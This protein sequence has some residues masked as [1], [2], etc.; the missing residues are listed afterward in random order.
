VSTL[1]CWYT[2]ALLGERIS[3]VRGLD[4]A[5]S[6]YGPDTHI[7]GAPDHVS[8]HVRRSRKK[9]A[10]PF[11]RLCPSACCRAGERIATTTYVLNAAFSWSRRH[12][13]LHFVVVVSSCALLGCAAQ[14]GQHDR[15]T[16]TN[17]IPLPVA[18]LT[19]PPEPGCELKP[20]RTASQPNRTLVQP[21]PGSSLAEGIRLEYERNC[22]QR[23]EVRVR[24]R[25]LRLQKAVRKTIRAIRSTERSG[26]Y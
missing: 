14:S 25:L 7:I 8:G 1:A 21:G 9:S 13:S 2:A 26:S 20:S 17:R 19:P 12:S 22:F 5:Y 16:T 11:A 3:W 4:N 15:L 18:L 23:A 10:P 6:C 24:D